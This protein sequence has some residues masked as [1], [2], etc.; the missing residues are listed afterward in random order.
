MMIA[1]PN[2]PMI[3][4]GHAAMTT[5]ALMTMT[6]A[7]APRP[8]NGGANNAT[9]SAGHCLPNC[10][11]ADQLRAGGQ[12]SNG[13]VPLPAGQGVL[14]PARNDD[15]RIGL[16]FIV[17]RPQWQDLRRLRRVWTKLLLG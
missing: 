11:I 5:T 16:F 15:R 2:S 3:S 12:E 14:H 8:G 1:A 6:I 13:A 17:R 4:T 9:C 10:D 7:V